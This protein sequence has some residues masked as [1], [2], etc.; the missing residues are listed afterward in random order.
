MAG[1]RAQRPFPPKLLT[2]RA[3]ISNPPEFTNRT[4]LNPLFPFLFHPKYFTVGPRKNETMPAQLYPAWPPELSS[5][6]VQYLVSSIKE[7]SITYGLAIRPPPTLRLPLPGS[8][9]LDGNDDDD[10]D[11]RQT[12]A[13]T[14]PVTLF[15]SP[16]P[17]SCFDEGRDIQE[18][19]NELYA[20][21]AA[22]QEWLGGIV[23]E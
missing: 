16:M 15:P 6:Q 21:V 13:V 5:E 4:S 18:A 23:R 10:D 3:S 14:A 2:S 20:A 17:R 11:R 7:W 1:G 9:E 12:L 22:D 8:S 19:Y